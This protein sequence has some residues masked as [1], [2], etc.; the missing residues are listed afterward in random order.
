M[1]NPELGKRNR[2]FE[3]TPLL[4]PV[5]EPEMNGLMETKDGWTDRR[6][7]ERIRRR[8]LVQLKVEIVK[9]GGKDRKPEDQEVPDNWKRAILS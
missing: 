7:K 8:L 4:T 6:R 3:A 9:R 5:R 2:I 1:L